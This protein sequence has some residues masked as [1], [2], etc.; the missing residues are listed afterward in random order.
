MVLPKSS[1]IPYFIELSKYLCS[2][3]ILLYL[4]TTCFSPEDPR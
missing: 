2:V 1:K 4:M 3:L